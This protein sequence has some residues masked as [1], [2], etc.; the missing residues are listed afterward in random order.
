MQWPPC[1]VV[2]FQGLNKNILEKFEV[3]FTEHEVGCDPSKKL[4]SLDNCL[5]WFEVFNY[6]SNIASCSLQFKDVKGNTKK[7]NCIVF[8]WY[9]VNNSTVKGVK[10]VKLEVNLSDSSFTIEP[11]Y[12]MQQCIYL[13]TYLTTY[14]VTNILPLTAPFRVSQGKQT[15]GGISQTKTMLR[16]IGGGKQ[17][18]KLLRCAGEKLNNN[19]SLQL[20]ETLGP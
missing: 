11:R 17:M 2:M 3:R 9:D 5:F 1:D 7:H 8:P 4:A 15:T 16:T 19:Y 6:F 10:L 14:S 13:P 18:G 20:Q 12:I